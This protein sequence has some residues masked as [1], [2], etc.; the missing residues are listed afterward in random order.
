MSLRRKDQAGSPRHPSRSQPRA[1]RHRAKE[2]FFAD[3]AAV[4]QEFDANFDASFDATFPASA[5]PERAPGHDALEVASAEREKACRE[6]FQLAREASYGLTARIQ[7]PAS[8]EW[9]A[10]LETTLR[11]GWMRLSNVHGWEEARAGVRRGWDFFAPCQH[12]GLG[13]LSHLPAAS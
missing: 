13:N 1:T 10:E 9:T 11:L 12:Q 8:T 7:R 2:P 6:R 5:I 3:D 4:I